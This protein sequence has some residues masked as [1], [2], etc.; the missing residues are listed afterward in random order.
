MRIWNR[1]QILFLSTLKQNVHVW[2][3]EHYNDILES[4]FLL[5]D[6]LLCITRLLLIAV[7]YSTSFFLVCTCLRSKMMFCSRRW[8]K[9]KYIYIIIIEIWWDFN[10]WPRFKP[11]VHPISYAYI[12]FGT[13]FKCHSKCVLDIFRY[14]FCSK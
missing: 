11:K 4:F 7:S 12:L 10:K 5:Y 2:S 3:K 6:K 9:K 14:L 8:K 1:I 13:K